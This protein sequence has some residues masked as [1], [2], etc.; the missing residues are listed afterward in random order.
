M[1]YPILYAPKT[2]D[3]DNLGLGVLSDATSANV[4]QELNGKFIFEM[5]YPVHGALYEQ[6]TEQ[7][8]IKV[9]AG[10][11]TRGQLFEIKR[12]VTDTSLMM[13][14]YAE[15]VSYKL[16]N[17]PIK[18]FTIGGNGQTMLN[19]L[20]KALLFDSDLYT[21]YSDVETLSSGTYSP[22]TFA[23]AR[24][25]LGGQDGS[26]LDAVGGQ[27][28]FDNFKISLLNQLGKESHDVLMYGRNIQSLSQE[29]SIM[30][31]YNAIYPYANVQQ[32]KGS[33]D[34][35]TTETVIKT[36]PNKVVKSKYFDSY[37]DPM[38]Q[39][40]DFS[41]KFTSKEGDGL[42]AYS[43]DKMLEL[44]NKY[45]SDNEIG[46]PKVTLTISTIDLYNAIT[47]QSD[48]GFE[49][50]DLGD[51][52]R[53]SFMDLNVD[54]TAQV[55][56]IVYDVL[57]E[58]YTSYTIG[59]K[60]KTLTQQFLSTATEAKKIAKQAID[61]SRQAALIAADG[62]LD[63][64][65]KSIN[66]PFPAEPKKGD[67]YFV[68]DGDDSYIFQW[69]GTTWLELV[70]TKT[71]DFINKAVD[72]AVAKASTYAENLS[73]M[74]SEATQSLASDLATKADELT[75]SQQRLSSQATLYTNS[76]AADAKASAAE[77]AR[78]AQN[79]LNTAKNSLSSEITSQAA[80]Y[81]S[82]AIAIEERA[83]N[84]L[85]TAK[86]SLSSEIASQAAAYT[87]SAIAIEER[88]QNALNTAKSSLSSAI[89]SQATATNSLVSAVDSN[90]GKYATQAKSEAV[91]AAQTAD[92]VVRSDFKKT[93]DSISTTIA[94]NKSEAD[95]KIKT[96]QTT[97][98]Q[99]LDGLAT[100]VSQTEYNTKT[101]QLQTDLTVTTQTAN[102][103]KTDIVSIKQKDGEQ[104]EKMNS[105]V[106]DV[107]GTKQTV[108]DLQTIQGKQSGDISTLKQRADGFE[109]TVTKVNNLSVGGRN[110]ILNSS[111]TSASNG[112]RP[113]LKGASSDTNALLS[114][115]DTGIQVSNNKGNTE[116]FYGLATAWTDI[117][118]TPLVAKSTY[119]IS[120]KAKGTAK[121]IAAR[122]GIRNAAT[123]YEVSLVNFTNINNS[124]WT[125]VTYTFTIP[126][127]ITHVFLRLQGA[128]A[129]S[130]NT[131]FD[132]GEAFTMKELKLELG[133]VST[134]LT[135]APEDLESATA[136]AQLTADQATLA[137][138]NYK[139]D[140]DG[141]ISKAQADI[142]VNA[143]AISTKVAKTDYDKKTGDLTTSVGKAQQ[144]ADSATQTIGTY[145]ES[146]DKRVSAAETNIKANSDAI[147]STVSKTDFDKATGKLTGD[148]STLQ[149]RA[150]GF[151]ATVTK[152]NNLA[153]GG[154]NLLTNTNKDVSITSHT[155]DGWPAWA[156]IDTG[157]SFENGKTYTFS[158]EA[159]NSTD[160]I[161]EASIRVFEESTNTQVGIYAFPADGKRH[162]VTFTIPNDSH[163]YRL[164][165]YAGHAGIAPGVDLTTTYH[166]PK[167]EAGNIATDWTPA[168]EDVDSAVAKAQLTA[169][170]ATLAINNY[171]TDADGRIR[172]AQ[173]D[174]VA[175]AN[176]ITQKVSQTDYNTKTGALTTSVSKAQ[177]TADS[178]TQTIG[179]YKESNDKRVTAAETNIKANSDAILQT[180][181]K[182]DFDKATGKLTGDISTL[183]QRADGFEATVTKVN[184]LSVGGGVNLL[185]G[186]GTAS[187]DV[188]EGGAVFVKDAF[189]GYDAVKTN[190]AWNERFINLYQALGR[191]NAKAGDWYTIS[192]YVKADKQID[193]GSLNVYRALGNSDAN[194]NDG[195][196]NAIS[197]QD[198]PIGTQWQQYAWSF[199]INNISLQ[200][201]N[202]RV[203]YCYDT[204]DN[205]I[206]WA[207]WVLEKGTVAHGWTPAPEDVDSAT[208]QAQLTADNA[209]VSINNY[210]TD[211]DGRIRKAQADIVAN[212]NAI[213]Q[214][215]SQTDYNT[216]TGAL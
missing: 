89:A 180:V 142:K 185:Q 66:D 130:Y 181:S 67:K 86:S 15:H 137:I 107:N 153:V 116:W 38:V 69:D 54:T 201:H 33:G 117:T 144:T 136:K 95:G 99:A 64:Y 195:H 46:I 171:K 124:D 12:I 100:K 2:T 132:G 211:A 204:G 57:S 149:Q 53:V 111:G 23:N 65:G 161:A 105:I 31:T 203:E 215:V 147:K 206:Y 193:T 62:T 30:D 104:D 40:V 134:D 198:K 51:T 20:Q 73:K 78:N 37:N 52:I 93:T 44:A 83:Q 189:N 71:G 123:N 176:A 26:I 135:P 207:G 102:Q 155:T 139:T 45:I 48:Q 186:T 158:A 172:K 82:S 194:S 27:Y 183:Q 5:N 188:S 50:L 138:N 129:N 120:F 14:I 197:M 88:A 35:A 156:H 63:S 18:D 76:M 70:S 168:P 165:F 91:A 205:W 60:K 164:L 122:V 112:V 42:P 94:Q 90:A 125:K 127:G 8:Y 10:M 7:A 79:E 80:A 114:Y 199:Q 202:T 163:N 58:Q 19:A 110:Y 133:N 106:S 216:K 16:A 159:K 6:I 21:F 72:S 84:A 74:Q 4:T 43:D 140:A 184:N 141:R 98:T 34:D 39:V 126:S 212:A 118:K 174:I 208:A 182:T 87:S 22:T 148:I 131:G 151:D 55:T 81:T 187:G 191:T 3:F 150:N 56:A 145:K 61:E 157:F 179:T 24:A 162:S 210:K 9:D 128:V 109:A 200:R 173:A 115:S 113:V 92:G 68:Q 29:Q 36:L 213:T 96:A 178:A 214:K 160:K 192:V 101:G 119:T 146:N 77:I 32:A 121:Q 41:D 103:A 47:P 97:A 25:V 170:N 108:S 59:E 143:D 49:S 166:H 17:I 13:S 1:A 154:R 85:N 175:N 11:S 167:L 152:V 169:D 28:K 190:H 209:T 177:Q 75:K 196:L